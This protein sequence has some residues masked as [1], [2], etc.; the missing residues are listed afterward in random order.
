MGKLRRRDTKPSLSVGKGGEKTAELP[1]NQMAELP[2]D[3]IAE[4]PWDPMA[5]QLFSR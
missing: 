2:W 5:E 3:L 4:P 1:W